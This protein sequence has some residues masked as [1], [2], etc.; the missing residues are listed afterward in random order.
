ME[1]FVEDIILTDSRPLSKVLNLIIMEAS[2]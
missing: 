2:Y 1:S